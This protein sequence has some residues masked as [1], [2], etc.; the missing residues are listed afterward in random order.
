MISKPP[1]LSLNLLRNSKDFLWQ[2]HK[3]LFYRMKKQLFLKTIVHFFENLL[4]SVFLGENNPA[5]V[6]KFLK[7]SDIQSFNLLPE[8]LIPLSLFD[9]K[10]NLSLNIRYL[11]V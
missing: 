11:V 5:G 1:D 7:Y 8:A 6:L 4:R 10:F 2:L 3:N 9:K